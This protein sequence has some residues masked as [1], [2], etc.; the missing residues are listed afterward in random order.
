MD[1][2]FSESAHEMSGKIQNNVYSSKT[3]A[4]NIIVLELFIGQLSILYVRLPIDPGE[5]AFFLDTYK[6]FLCAY[7]FS[8]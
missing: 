8:G 5:G 4:Y 1:L 3:N 2:K 6:S 7:Q